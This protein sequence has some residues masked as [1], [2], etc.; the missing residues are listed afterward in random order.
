[1]SCEQ[2][3]AH[4]F[5]HMSTTGTVAAE[6]LEKLYQQNRRK[7]G[8]EAE[9]ISAEAKT[10]LFFHAISASGLKPPTHAA[11]GLPKAESQPGYA[12]VYDQLKQNGLLGEHTLLEKAAPAKKDTALFPA[13]DPALGLDGR[14][15]EGYDR[16]GYDVNG[17]NRFEFDREGFDKNGYNRH[18][19]N[20][21]GMDP[22][23]QNAE[24]YGRDGFNAQNYDRNGFDKYG[25]SH[26][27]PRLD[28]DGYD[29]NG[30]DKNG[31]DRDG[32]DIHGR[33][34]NG[35]PDP[36]FMPDAN[37]IYP[38]GFDAHGYGIDGYDRDGYDRW[39]FG[40]DGYNLIGYDRNGYDRSGQLA[41]RAVD[42]QGY[43]SGG[44]KQQMNGRWIDRC[45]YDGWGYKDGRSFTG[46]DVD[47]KDA[48]GAPRKV[49][50][51][52]GKWVNAKYDVSGFDED[53]YDQWGFH[54]D[55]GLSA[56]DKK[57]RRYNTFGWI[58]DDASGDCYNPQDPT[59]R[60]KNE[61]LFNN[62][63]KSK[64]KKVVSAP[65]VPPA[66]PPPITP[67]ATIE[68][69]QYDA[70]NR[71]YDF[72]REKMDQ[73]LSY[74]ERA[75]MKPTIPWRRGSLDDKVKEGVRMR[76]PQCGQFTGGKAHACP[77]FN[78]QMVRSLRSGVV[79]D[80]NSRTLFSPQHPEFDPEY[81]NNGGYSVITGLDRDGFDAYGRNDR[82]YDREGYDRVGYDIFGYDRDGYDRTGYNNRGVNRRG[83]KR[84]TSLRDVQE[85]AAEEGRDLLANDD[86]ARMYG[87]IASGLI[88]KPRQVILKEGGGFATDMKGR[89][90][91]D[92]YPLGRDA[93]PRHNLIVTRAGIYHELGH[94]Q[95]T[96]QE[97]WARILEAA[98]GKTDVGL[99]EAARQMLPRFYNIVEDGRMEREVAGQY[100]GAAE[101]LAASCRL[102]PRWGEE[103]GEGV[104]DSDQVFW[105]L[106]Y[107][108]L[109]YFRVRQEVRN[110]MTPRARKVFEELEP[111]MM[112]AVRG[113]PEEVYDSFGANCEAFRRRGLHPIAEEGLFQSDAEAAGIRRRAATTGTA[114]FGFIRSTARSAGF[115]FIWSTARSAEL[116]FIWP[117][118]RPTRFRL[119]WSTTRSAGLRFFQP[120]A[121]STRFRFIRERIK[122]RRGTG[123]GPQESSQTGG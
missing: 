90:Y 115:R 78:G 66:P 63:K 26:Q 9:R 75:N 104:S 112:R 76:C 103:V 19:F 101:I 106:L 102:E 59:Q 54:R 12:A 56:P 42:A 34:R 108:G 17:F 22:Y 55:T 20:R 35:D 28:V 21:N 4:F 122:K 30:F 45:G 116:G 109:P 43:N 77:S 105:S 3:R 14:D 82:G 51:D 72:P 86:L 114:R 83:E 88:G 1:M 6:D 94:E 29:R 119:I 71:Y 11:D 53:G 91:A 18:R 24:G 5:K 70:V 8:S 33:D 80:K 79:I 50:N 64:R 57:G 85:L 93:D 89:I 73:Y 69:Q 40:R 37:G 117:A 65:Y 7:P 27:E 36:N 32:Y 95:F 31:Y 96:P 39:G 13:N 38:D 2:S 68:Y 10:R 110:G 41:S 67:F 60:V 87:Q 84:G 48:N 100:K 52:K 98:E 113:T 25:Y 46:Y 23:S 16:W 92:P 74:T 111:V 81:D 49:L 44:R 121:R 58:H 120:T 118:A 97:I 99:G 107:T 15:A 62:P 61:F 47:G 123:N